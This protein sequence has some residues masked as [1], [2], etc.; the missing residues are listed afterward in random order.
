M[1]FEFLN[2]IHFCHGILV[3]RISCTLSAHCTGL[4]DLARGFLRNNAPK[5]VQSRGRAVGK[6]KFARNSKFHIWLLIGHTIVTHN[7]YTDEKKLY[8]VS[9]YQI[10]GSNQPE[11]SQRARESRSTCGRAIKQTC[12]SRSVKPFSTI[13]T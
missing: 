3:I 9:L 7:F 13:S 1:L 11:F 8:T 5:P 6:V 12:R 2:R 10:Y 4:H